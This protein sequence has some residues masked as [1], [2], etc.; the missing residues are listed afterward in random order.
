MT[1][2]CNSCSSLFGPQMMLCCHFFDIFHGA[3]SNS[4]WTIF[5]NFIWKFLA[6]LEKKNMFSRN[7][8]AKLFE[9]LKFDSLPTSASF[10]VHIFW[11]G[12]TNGLLRNP[13]LY[14]TIIINYSFVIK[15]KSPEVLFHGITS[16]YSNF[17]VILIFAPI[18]HE[19]KHDQL[20][21]NEKIADK[22]RQC[23][24][25]LQIKPKFKFAVQLN[26]W[27]GATANPAKSDKKK[28]KKRGNWSEFHFSEVTSYKIHTLI[29]FIRIL[30]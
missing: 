3:C 26:F 24:D 6:K 1:P 10:K 20:N 22:V 12:H 18:Q 2:L 28:M 15:G 30:F 19:A 27:L 25:F 13:E 17:E 14:N 4:Q 21:R 7:S 23:Y 29:E 8:T 16:S 9:K 5:E 11:E